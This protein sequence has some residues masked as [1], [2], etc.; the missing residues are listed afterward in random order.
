MDTIFNNFN[1]FY[2]GCYT[3]MMWITDPYEDRKTNWVKR[4]KGSV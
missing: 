3:F 1:V 2:R 4:K